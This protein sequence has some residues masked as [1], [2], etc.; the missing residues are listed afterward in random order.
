METESQGGES[1]LPKVTVGMRSETEMEIA[2]AAPCPELGKLF[3]A[4]PSGVL[5]VGGRVCGGGS[6][7]AG[8]LF[9]ANAGL[10]EFQSTKHV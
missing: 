5:G 2:K 1:D 6:R 9:N 10:R 8:W 4:S 7:G 3:A